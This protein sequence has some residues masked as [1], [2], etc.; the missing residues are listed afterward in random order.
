MSLESANYIASLD[1]TNPKGGDQRSTA[2]EHLR[3]LKAVLDK[4]FNTPPY[5]ISDT[6]SANA[7]DLNILAGQGTIISAD[8]WKYF[9]NLTASLQAQIDNK[10]AW[11]NGVSSQQ[12]VRSHFEQPIFWGHNH[13]RAVRSASADGELVIGD[14]WN[15]VHNVGA[16]ARKVVIP[17]TVSVSWVVGTEIQLVRF[18]AGT[19]AVTAS[20][21]GVVIY[22]LGDAHGISSQYGEAMLRMIGANEWLLF[23]EGGDLG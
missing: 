13:N 16:T 7:A 22:A 6:V 4:T 8:E 21:A 2:D 20:A 12:S 23:S 3:L 17:S 19:F 15:A 14:A 18:G 1:E 11:G 9:E 5:K 10:A